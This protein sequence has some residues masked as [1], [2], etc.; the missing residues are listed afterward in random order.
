[1]PGRGAEVGAAERAAAVGAELRSAC[2]WTPNSGRQSGGDLDDQR[3]DM[4]LRAA[5]V[6]LVDHGAQVAVHGSGAVMMIELV[7]G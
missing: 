5:L 6:E 2:H 3:L 1:M 4:H 7:G